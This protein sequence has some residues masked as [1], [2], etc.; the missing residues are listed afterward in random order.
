MAQ[1]NPRLYNMALVGAYGGTNERWLVDQIAAD[2]LPKIN[3]MVAFAN[4][5]DSLIPTINTGPAM[6]QVFSMLS[7][8][9]GIWAGRDISSISQSSYLS[10]ATAAVALWN[11]VNL[12][13]VE[14]PTVLAF[15]HFHEGGGIQKQFNVASIVKQ[16]AGS[17]TYLVSF[18]RPITVDSCDFPGTFHSSNPGDQGLMIEQGGGGN[19]L[20]YVRFNLNNG[21]EDGDFSFTVTGMP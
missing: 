17:G 9:Q 19:T 4:A 5:V 14:I 8:C 20:T 3:A 1:N 2:Y 13:L 16:G 12:Q 18:T 10:M 7:I 15:A 11:E 6:N 21:A